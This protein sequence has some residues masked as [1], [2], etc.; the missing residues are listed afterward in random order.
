MIVVYDKET[1]AI[2]Y[3][4]EDAAHHS[5]DNLNENEEMIITRD[6]SVR[7][8]THRVSN[9]M[10]MC[11]TEQEIMAEAWM[12]NK[13]ESSAMER[14]QSQEVDLIERLDALRRR[15]AQLERTEFG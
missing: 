10:I 15:L 14:L 9:G 6:G 8:N 5:R 4:I 11:K 3:T 7:T 12:R 2:V 1:R 13:Q